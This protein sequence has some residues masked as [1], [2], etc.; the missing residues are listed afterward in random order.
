M[1]QRRWW[2][3]FGEKHGLDATWRRAT[4][5]WQGPRS[6]AR[7]VGW[8]GWRIH[9]ESQ[10]QFLCEQL[11]Q[12]HVPGGTRSVEQWRHR[13]VWRSA[14][15]TSYSP[16]PAFGSGLAPA[17][18]SRHGDVLMLA[19][20]VGSDSKKNLQLARPVA[21]LAAAHLISCSAARGASAHSHRRSRRGRRGYWPCS[22]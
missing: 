22:R 21:I 13:L 8:R 20:L 5:L 7:G 16:S 19:A 4:P 6:S 9:C 12:L 10:S 15:P 17:A 14:S 3:G 18:E 1:A 2:R 11:L